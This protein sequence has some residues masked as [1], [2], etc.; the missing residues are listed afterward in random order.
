MKHR[1]ILIIIVLWGCFPALVGLPLPDVQDNKEERLVKADSIDR[2]VELIKSALIEKDSKRLE[3]IKNMN[4]QLI[5]GNLSLAI[6]EC[7]KYLKES[8]SNELSGNTAVSREDIRIA[9]ILAEMY[10]EAEKST[11]L[12]DKVCKLRK[13]NRNKKEKWIEAN[14]LWQ[15]GYECYLNYKFNDV[16]NFCDKSKNL[17]KEIRYKE[18]EANCFY[19]I[20]NAHNMLD[21]YDKAEQMYKD[22]LILIVKM[23]NPLEEANCIRGLGVLNE[24]LGKYDKAIQLYNDSLAIYRRINDRL[25]AARCLFNI[26]AINKKLSK[27]LCV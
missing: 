12:S 4:T 8:V 5:Q 13:W 18:G 21:E 16:I 2:L 15:K 14:K 6:Q 17:Y 10:E 1:V 3:Q 25:R 7:G 26:G 11:Y 22:G 27:S 19:L 20:G 24:M 9:Q 23:K